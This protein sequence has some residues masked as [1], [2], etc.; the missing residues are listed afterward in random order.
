MKSKFGTFLMIIGAALLIA[1]LSL[2]MMNRQEEQEAEES[3]NQLLEMVEQQVETPDY[4]VQLPDPYDPTMTEKE[5]EGYLYI[6]YLTIP[7]LG[8]ELPIMSDWSY[9][10]LRIA[11][12]RYSGSSKSDDLVLM[13]HNYRSHFGQ[14]K[15]LKE[16]D[17]V[18]FTDMDNEVT[19]YE[20]VALD[21]LSP[22]AVEEMIAGDYDLTLFTCTYG[23][24]SRV[25]VR[26]EE[27]ESDD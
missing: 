5:I 25:T 18:V 4:S 14:L 7:S 11:P 19:Q 1:A 27:I 9:A 13:A 23:G 6:G 15:T 2:F 16:G 20:V 26:C 22:T 21:V 10:Q 17:Q 12:C 8:L 24:K 3:S